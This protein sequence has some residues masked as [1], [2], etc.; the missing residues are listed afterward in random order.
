VPASAF[1]LGE[2]GHELAAVDLAGNGL[3][4]CVY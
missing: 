4:L 3:A 2:L 1:D